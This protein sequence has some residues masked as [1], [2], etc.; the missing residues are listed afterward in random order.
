MNRGQEVP[1]AA[2]AVRAADDHLG[3][4]SDNGFMSELSTH[5]TIFA[6][7]TLLH[8]FRLFRLTSSIATTSQT[9]KTA[10][11]WTSFPRTGPGNHETSHQFPHF[12]NMQP[13]SGT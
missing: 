1:E 11:I 12:V 3:D 13:P 2:P 10:H 5:V 7:Y 4:K 8:I 6:Q 9:G